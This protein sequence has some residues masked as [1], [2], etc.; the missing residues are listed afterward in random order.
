[1]PCLR[2]LV[3]C[4]TFTVLLASTAAGQSAPFVRVADGS[5]RTMASAQATPAA[6]APSASA[7]VGVCGSQGVAH[8]GQTVPGGGTLATIAHANA[9]TRA[10]IGGSAFYSAIDG[11]LRNQG[12]FVAD[13]NGLKPIVVGCGGGGGSGVPGSG[14]GDPTPIGGTFSGLF[15]GTFFAPASN[16]RGDVLFLAD[17]DG[18]SSSRGL[19]AFVSGSQTIQKV[20]AIGDP[21]PGG[22]TIGAVGPGVLDDHT[23]AVFVARRAEAPFDHV[24]LKWGSEVMQTFLVAAEGDPAPLG[25]TFANLVSE[26]LGFVDGTT[27]PVGP[28]PDVDN[29]GTTCFRA[30]TSL[31]TRGIIVTQVASPQWYV[32]AGDATPLGGT[33]FDF[34][35][36]ILND[37]GQVAFFADWK[38]TPS[39]FNSGWFVGKPGN[40][41]AALSFNAPVPGGQCVGLAFS[42]N[43]MQPLDEFG[44][45]VQ[46]IAIDQGGGVVKEAQVISAADGSVTLVAQQ[47]DP[48]PL[49]GSYS[50][51]DAWP[52]LEALRGTFGAATPGGAGLNA[53][54]QFE[55]CT[56][57]PSTYCTP[58]TNSQGCIPSISASGASS[59]SA[60]SGFSIQASNVLNQT[61]GLLIYNTF[62]PGA[63]PFGGGLLCLGG[64]VLRTP[65]QSSG[66][67]AFPTIDCS[68]AYVLDMNAFATGALGGSPEGLLS[69]P[70]T[71]VFTQFWSRDTGFAP[72]Q[73]IGL[74]GGLQYTVG[75]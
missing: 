46:W 5:I 16:L 9:A 1:M 72:P 33:Y 12:I 24:I 39:T 67:S 32:R 23:V 40:W 37:D 22:G 20:A 42:R 60:P 52:S 70:G 35:G 53:Y 19:F 45:L 18:G 15:G 62:G 51:F 71:E 63:T 8:C 6:L 48:T 49:G 27:I 31:G 73:N 11:S 66:G 50:T 14:V 61:V 47:G 29:K 17:V 3:R 74:T 44:N 7:P 4:I 65:G 41:R 30:I 55:L 25:G 38:P 64:L 34:Q 69:V 13:A 75:I 68:G 59:A 57:P 56:P 36:A 54:L 2:P 43:P 21:I 28:L 10:G 58:K 26:T